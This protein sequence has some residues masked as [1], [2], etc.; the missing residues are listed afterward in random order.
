MG[1]KVNVLSKTYEQQKAVNGISF[2]ATP[3]KILGLLGPNGA[4][5]S[6]TMKMLS[7][8]LTP[9]SG[10]AEIAGF[11]ISTQSLQVKS[12]LGYLPE[13]TPLYLDMYVREFLD[14]VASTYQL[15]NKVERVAQVINQVGCRRKLIK[16]S[17]CFQKGTSNVWD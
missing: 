15:K 2:E 17:T 11:D 4:G 3:G 7:C 1:V 8:Y 6:T 9:T 5:K 12:I 14:F 10:S 16:R 13:N